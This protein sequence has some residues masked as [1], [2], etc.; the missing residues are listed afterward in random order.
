MARQHQQSLRQEGLG[1]DVRR[2]FEAMTSESLTEQAD[3]ESADTLSFSEFL[4]QYLR[5]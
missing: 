3:M 2:A 1:D 4:E 5:S